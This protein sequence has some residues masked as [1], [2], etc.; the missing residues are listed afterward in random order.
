M[1]R[2]LLSKSGVGVSVEVKQYVTH[3]VCVRFSP[4]LYPVPRTPIWHNQHDQIR[5]TFGVR[6]SGGYL[7]PRSHTWKIPDRLIDEA[8]RHV[9]KT[10]R[11]MPRHQWPDKIKD[12]FDGTVYGATGKTFEV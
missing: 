7:A 9:A 10:L 6:K 5:V 8:A 2:S 12:H 3:E 11:K 4:R 1:I